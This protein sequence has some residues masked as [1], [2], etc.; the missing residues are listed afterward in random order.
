MNPL[1]L[2]WGLACGAAATGCGPKA[3]P[4]STDSGPTASDTTDPGTSTSGISSGTG[5]TGTTGT[6][7]TPTTTMPGACDT[8]DCSSSSSSGSS[9][10]GCSFLNCDDAGSTCAVMVNGLMVRCSLCDVF[11]QDCPDGQ[12]CT[13]AIDDGGGSWNTTRCVEVAGTDV[14]GDE[15]SSE[16]GA[17]GVD[18]CVKGAMCWGVD[19]M[20]IGIC[21]ALCTGTPDSPICAD[22]KTCAITN[23]GVLNLCLQTCDP[24]LQDCLDP[25]EVCYPISDGFTC[26]PDASGEEGQHND[27][28][29]FINT[30][31]KGLMCADA[32]FVGAGCVPPATSCC[33]EFCECTMWDPVTF[34]C[35]DPA[36][37]CP[38]PDQS[39]VQYFT[40]P[41]PLQPANAEDIGVCGVPQ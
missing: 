2:V 37:K 24:L 20:G 18:S 8:S 23:D 17:S 40:A 25:N 28:C 30:C 16:G 14:P 15:C 33:T 3:D 36:V 32:A 21:V 39:C 12:K 7:T 41:F 9:S 29:A 6:T 35:Q 27:S 34:K 4:G 38:N 13:A 19:D 5:T 22:G 31:D 1:L 11:A 10:G 26:A